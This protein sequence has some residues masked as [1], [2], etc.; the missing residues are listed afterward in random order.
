MRAALIG[1][2]FSGKTTLFEALSG[3][4]PGRKDENLASIKVP[5]ERIDFLASVFNPGKK[6]YTEFL[7]H[8]F[9]DDAK[10]EPLPAKIKNQ[11]QKMDVLIIVLRDFPSTMSNKPQDPLADYL[12]IREELIFSDL[13]IVE[14]KLEREAK[15][16]K[17]APDLPV[18]KKLHEIFSK[19][20]IPSSADINDEEMKQCLNYSFL[21]LKK[22]VILINKPEGEVSVPKELETRLAEEGLQFFPV[23]ALLEKEL[24]TLPPE[25]IASFLQGFGLTETAKKRLLKAVYTAMDLISFLTVGEDEVRA[26]TI[27]RGA[28]AVEAAGRIHSDIARGFIRA[29][30][31][32]YETF[33]KLGSESACKE[34][35]AYKLTGKDYIVNDGD[36]VEFRF[37]V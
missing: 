28:P 32:P 37:N 16:H 35:N 12:K 25:D 27:R 3:V 22:L 11:L 14:K 15:E 18:L 21:T 23:S 20:A 31:V 26:W 1:M 29:S 17:N 7:L 13:L 6:T 8:D 34:A 4:A 10:T 24:N 19:N 5:D 2:P 36:I 33:K 30:V 9:N